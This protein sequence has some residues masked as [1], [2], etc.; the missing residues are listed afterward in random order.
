MV[1]RC[2]MNSA[3]MGLHILYEL[4]EDGVAAPKQ[5]GAILM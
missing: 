4:H 5:V 2:V 3:V 1:H